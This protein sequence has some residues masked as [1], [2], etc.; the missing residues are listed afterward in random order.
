MNKPFKG[1]PDNPYKLS[2]PYGVSD[3]KEK[4]KAFQK[5]SDAC[6]KAVKE[7]DA[8]IKEEINWLLSFLPEWTK[9]VPKGLDPTLYGTGQYEADLVVKKRI[10]QIISKLKEDKP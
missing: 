10:D 4:Y 8:E 2:T 5:A 9:I 6:A 7:R 1:W 3:Q